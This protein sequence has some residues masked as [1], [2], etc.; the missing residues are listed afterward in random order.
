MTL[1]NTWEHL[2]PLNQFMTVSAILLG[3]TQLSLRP[4]LRVGQQC[5]GTLASFR[6]RGLGFPTGVADDLLGVGTRVGQQLVGLR[7]RGAGQTVGGVLRQAE[8]AGGLEGLLL[9]RLR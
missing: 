3:L 4:G 5:V 9:I 6:H 8:H 1:Y 2:Q 7:L